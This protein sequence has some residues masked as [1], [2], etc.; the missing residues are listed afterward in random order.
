MKAAAVVAAAIVVMLVV[1][2]QGPE[3]AAVTCNPSELSPCAAALTSNTP[4]TK[5]CCGKLKEQQPCFC[6][7]LKNP[8]LQKFISSPNAKKV[9]SS[10]GVAVPK[11]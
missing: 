7:Y 9:A 11:C 10:C 4:P 3:V 2:G 5:V 1:V 8:N 6:Q